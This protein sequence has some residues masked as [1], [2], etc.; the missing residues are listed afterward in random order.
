MN[1]RTLR[2]FIEVYEKKSIAAAAKEVYISPQ[3]LSKIIRQ[4][5]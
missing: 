1:T 3:G 2:C 4:L 5:E